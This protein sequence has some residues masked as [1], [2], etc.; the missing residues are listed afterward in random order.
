MATLKSSEKQSAEILVIGL[1]KKSGSLTIESGNSSL[2]STSLSTKSLLATLQDLGATGK[3]DEV[4]KIPLNTPLGSLR[5]IVVTGLGESQKDYSAETL[6]RSAGAAVRSLAGHK[7]ADF[8]LP[9]SSSAQFAAIAEG[10]S[11]AAYNFTD[12]RGSTKA[13]QKAPLAQGNILSKIGA[14]PKEKLR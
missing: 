11:L 14:T 8:D 4:I 13:E 10:V 6:R 5:M 1:A 12:F 2:T 7:S 3:A 9:H